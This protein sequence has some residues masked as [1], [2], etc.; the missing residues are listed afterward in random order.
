[1]HDRTD[2]IPKTN[3]NYYDSANWISNHVNNDG[4]DTN[5]VKNS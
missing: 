1:M 2:R 3:K 5:D 4:S